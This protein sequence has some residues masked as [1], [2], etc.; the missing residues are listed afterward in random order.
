MDLG[1]LKDDEGL[2]LLHWAADRGQVPEIKTGGSNDLLRSP[3]S[4]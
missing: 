1:E 2:T 4:Y 3:I